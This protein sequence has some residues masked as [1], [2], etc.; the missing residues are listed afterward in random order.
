M[1][2]KVSSQHQSAV[3]GISWR[4]FSSLV[5]AKITEQ[6]HLSLNYSPPPDNRETMSSIEDGGSVSTD[7]HGVEHQMQDEPKA[8]LNV[9]D[10]TYQANV[11][12]I[13]LLGKRFFTNSILTVVL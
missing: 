7:Q 6:R 10:L 13:F 9:I 4:I 5:S 1:H 11:W 8:I 12:Q 3:G 2:W